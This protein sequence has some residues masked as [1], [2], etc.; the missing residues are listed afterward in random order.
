MDTS[1]SSSIA[2]LSGLAGAVIGAAA[3]LYLKDRFGRAKDLER[4]TEPHWTPRSY[5]NQSDLGGG[6]TGAQASLNARGRN[7][8]NQCLPLLS[9]LQPLAPEADREYVDALCGIVRSQLTE[10]VDE[11]GTEGGPRVARVDHLFSMLLG[12]VVELGF[13]LGLDRESANTVSDEQDV[14]NYRL[15]VD[16]ITSLQRSWTEHRSSFHH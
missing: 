8:L 15:I 7:V 10:I 12:L 16:Y 13:Q 4:H 14:T 3:V 2:F 9:G 5:T 11:L 1:A 6:I